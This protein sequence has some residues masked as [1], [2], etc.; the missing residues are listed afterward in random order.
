MKVSK[1]DVLLLLGF[2]GILAAVCSYL[3]VFQP[4]ME[5]AQALTEENKQLEARIADL[6]KKSD[7]RDT[8]ES[9]TAQMRREIE[10]IYQL[11]P[12]DV[13]EEN[14]V[15]LAI[16][17]ELLS[18]L[19]MESVTIEALV[20]VPFMDEVQQQDM[21]DATY[22][23][24]E[25]EEIEDATGTQDAPTPDAG[26]T[27]NAAGVNP[28]HLMNRKATLNYEVSYEGLKR[29]VKNICMQ[30]DRMVIDN[31]S[32]VYD[33]QTGLLKGTTTVNMFCV[34]GQEGKEYEEP[35][36]G[37]V[38]LGTNNIFGT[39]VIRS[40]GNLPDLED[41]QAEGNAEAAAQ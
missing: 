19:K 5:K 3:F 9:Q 11:F 18:P 12:V 16:N 14:A 29:S 21:P 35:D 17:Q 30:T 33:E 24:E 32:V 34:P 22:E 7:N 13:R 40:E 6:Q 37:G 39:R 1:R 26:N 25:V 10:E 36:F 28:F 2:L 27:Q 15:I 38:L 4:T 23:I 31:L 8:Y 20:E 41:A